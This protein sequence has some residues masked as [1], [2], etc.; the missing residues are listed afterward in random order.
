MQITCRKYFEYFRRHL[1]FLYLFVA[2]LFLADSIWSADIFTDLLFEVVCF[3]YHIII[4]H[5][6]THYAL[7]NANNVHHD[8]WG[9]IRLFGGLCTV[10]T[11]LRA[12]F[13][14]LELYRE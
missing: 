6:N 13:P 4:M 12:N 1:L 14:L 9:V 8:V 5:V 11:I 3:V 7:T 2:C 10:S